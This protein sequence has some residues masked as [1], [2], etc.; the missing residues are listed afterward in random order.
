M[1]CKKRKQRLWI[2]AMIGSRYITRQK[3]ETGGR[4]RHW[5]KQ[6]NVT[7]MISHKKSLK[8]KE[9]QK[10]N[11]PKNNFLFFFFFLFP[12]RSEGDVGP[13]RKHY[14]KIYRKILFESRQQQNKREEPSTGGGWNRDPTTRRGYRSVHQEKGKKKK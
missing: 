7:R 2:I 1:L 6:T 13:K 8:K 12:R 9:E 3:V 5:K 14:N 4:S 11:W 10:E